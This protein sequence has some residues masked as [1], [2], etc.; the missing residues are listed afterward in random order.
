M[1]TL[2]KC[3]LSTYHPL[4]IPLVFA[5]I[6]RNRHF[7]LTDRIRSKLLTRAL[8][9]SINTHGPVPS[10]DVNGT[11]TNATDT[12]DT[13][14]LWLDMSHIKNGLESWRKQLLKITRHA[15]A[16]SHLEVSSNEWESRPYSR[17]SDSTPVTTQRFIE[18][19]F[20]NFKLQPPSG[21]DGEQSKT[22][23]RILARLEELDEEYD[24]KIRSCSTIVDG[25]ILATQMVRHFIP[26]RP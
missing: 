4:V 6:E 18:D 2:E 1:N 8:N 11:Q 19:S 13:L 20:D 26:E 16:L 9:V 24:E 17:S 22:M 5:E 14:R 21:D 10:E 25:M 3:D 7:K 23:P 15:K 12:D